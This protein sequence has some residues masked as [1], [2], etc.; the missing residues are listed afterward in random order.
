MRA[1]VV[2]NAVWDHQRLGAAAARA[3]T[4]R[5]SLAAVGMVAVVA[6]GFAVGKIRETH[7]RRAGRVAGHAAGN[8]VRARHGGGGNSADDGEEH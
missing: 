1:V 4:G 5:Q 6:L 8:R 3:C 2:G 7:E